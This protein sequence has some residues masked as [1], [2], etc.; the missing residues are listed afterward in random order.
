L[1]PRWDKRKPVD[2]GRQEAI[3]NTLGKLVILVLVFPAISAANSIPITA[4]AQL[5]GAT[6]ASVNLTGTNLEVFTITP[7]WP[8]NV[9]ECAQGQQCDLSE[10]VSHGYWG[11]SSGT[12]N[13][14][15]AGFVNIDITLTGSALAPIEGIDQYFSLQLPVTFA[16][17]VQ[18]YQ[19]NPQ[20]S[21]NVGPELWALDFSGT[22][23][24]TFWGYGAGVDV[25]YEAD[26]TLSGT[27]TGAAPEASSLVLVMLGA[28]LCFGFRRNRTVI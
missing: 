1:N 15:Y 8:T 25:F 20:D 6:A 9:A 21:G 19:A 26:Y 16:G 2:E 3:V 24:A 12:F 27:A 13:G 7:D 5:V 18:G 4:A 17:N 14:L 23:T 11:L 10:S 22:G 28:A